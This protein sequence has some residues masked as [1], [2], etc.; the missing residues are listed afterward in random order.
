MRMSLLRSPAT[1]TSKLE[2]YLAAQNGLTISDLHRDVISS[3]A[4]QTGN[5][6][7]EVLRAVLARYAA[8][9]WQAENNGAYG[10]VFMARG[11]IDLNK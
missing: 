9:G 1:H 4:L 5:D 6:L 2:A 3:E 7:R 11:W 8:G 10:F